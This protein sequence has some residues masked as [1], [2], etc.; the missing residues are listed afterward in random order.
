MGFSLG[1]GPSAPVWKMRI[2]MLVYIRQ[3][4]GWWNG[5]RIKMPCALIFLAWLALHN[6]PGRAPVAWAWPSAGTYMGL[7]TSSFDL[8]SDHPSIGTRNGGGYQLIFGR[9]G[10]RHLSGEIVMSGG[11]RFIAG[12]VPS[13]Y[14]PEDSA[15]YGYFMF[16]V[17]FHF[18]DPA[19][20]VLSP[21]L[22]LGWAW[23]T[24]TWNTYFY[25]IDGTS[26]T[27]YAGVDILLGK[28]GGLLRL[29][30]KRH[31]IN[32]SSG[33]YGGNYDVDVAELNVSF[34]YHFK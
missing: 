15:E 6:L 9:Y 11:L 5:R 21:W 33:L 1:D 19:K 26:L 18:M 31:S 8:D 29:D 13:P 20:H 28:S 2:A 7:G 22:G 34:G 24:I 32:A 17:R 14:Y 3:G 16:G 23:H 30:L 25:E 10:A 4:D 27:P 12:P